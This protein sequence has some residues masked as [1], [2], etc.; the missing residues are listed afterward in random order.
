M[1]QLTN[2]TDRHAAKLKTSILYMI[3]TA[4][5]YVVTLLSATI[6][7]FVARIKVCGPSKGPAE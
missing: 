2:S 4:L 1:G 7:S 3:Q 6:D 5:P